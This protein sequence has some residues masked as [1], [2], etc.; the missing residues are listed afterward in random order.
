MLVKNGWFKE[1]IVLPISS[2]LVVIPMTATNSDVGKPILLL[3]GKTCT[4]RAFWIKARLLKKGLW[5]LVN[6]G[7][8]TEAK[9]EKCDAFDFFSDLSLNPFSQ[10]SRGSHSERR[11]GESRKTQREYGYEYRGCNWMRDSSFQIINWIN[12]R[13]L[14]RVQTAFANHK[15]AGGG[16]SATSVALAVQHT[17]SDMPELNQ[18]SKTFS[19]TNN[20]AKLSPAS[21]HSK[22]VIEA[23]NLADRDA[24]GFSVA[25]GHTPCCHWERTNNLSDK[26]WKKYPKLMPKWM[27]FG[28]DT[29]KRRV[30]KG[31]SRN[32]TMSEDASARVHKV[33]TVSNDGSLTH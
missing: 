5:R 33:C 2:R 26:C 27:R 18:L 23:R 14:Q 4:M 11:V 30:R 12:E 6:T 19:L 8:T 21:I 20:H 16:V 9:Q 31:P 32:L 3:R 29:A 15:S 28:R 24:S 17:F 1:R 25:D 7:P 22:F 10:S 13:S